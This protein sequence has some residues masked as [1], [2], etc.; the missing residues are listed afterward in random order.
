MLQI[1]AKNAAQAS[2]KRASGEDKVARKGLRFIDLKN[3]KIFKDKLT[4]LMNYH[5]FLL[6][7]LSRMISIPSINPFGAFDPDKPAEA[8]M[9]FF[10]EKCLIKNL[11]L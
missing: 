10:F 6:K 4:N 9:G 8:A 2:R 7:N 3:E 5:N 1:Y 11:E